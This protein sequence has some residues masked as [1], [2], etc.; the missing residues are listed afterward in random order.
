[1]TVTSTIFVQFKLVSQ[2]YI[3]PASCQASM[4]TG[5]D[6]F[7]SNHF[8][9]TVWNRLK[10]KFSLDNQTP[11]GG[12]F[13]VFW[14]TNEKKTSL[15]GGRC[16][17]LNACCVV[18]REQATTCSPG[19]SQFYIKKMCCVFFLRFFFCFHKFDCIYWFF[20]A[21]VYLQCVFMRCC[22]RLF[23]VFFFLSLTLPVTQ[24]S[25]AHWFDVPIFCCVF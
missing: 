5:V 23:C 6:K 3:V 10:F 22:F 20:F 2:P 18:F 8:F 14:W 1:M 19:I 25:N 21:R 4:S 12:R 16:T 15:R 24:A 13:P 9:E 17:H 7:W 11:R